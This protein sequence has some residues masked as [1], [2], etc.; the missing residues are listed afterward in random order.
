MTS[1]ERKYPTS[2]VTW[3]LETT[4]LDAKTEKI[5]EIGA[6]KVVDGEITERKSWLIN[7]GIFLSE[8]TTQ[9]TGITDEMID[10]ESVKPEVAFKEFMSM[11]D[12]V[13]NYAN[14]THNG[15]KF[16]MHF[17]FNSLPESLL[18]KYKK[19]LYLNM[20]DTAVLVKAEKLDLEQNNGEL[21]I[22][23][24]S[25]V[26]NIRAFGVKYNIPLCCEEL[27]IDTSDAT[28]HRALGDATLTNEIYKKLCLN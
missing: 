22:S 4:G 6:I 27:K 10:A 9:I 8:K 13:P 28:F 24:A 23:F 3:D 19:D 20:I 26:M 21:F 18:E 12:D 11:F 1:T 5:I 2:Y 25:R 17:L 14:V 16:D 15:Y 7:H